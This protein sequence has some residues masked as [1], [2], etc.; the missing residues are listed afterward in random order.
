VTRDTPSD[1][2]LLDKLGVKPGSRVAV[3]E[4]ADDNFWS[5]LRRRT[6]EISDGGSAGA[7][8]MVVWQV[9]DIAELAGLAA[10]EAW[11]R[12]HGALWAVWR[13]GRPAL[14]E[15]HVRDAALAA[16]LVDV[17]VVRFSDTL[18]ALKLVIPKARR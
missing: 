6:D 12:P 2:P 15:N 17:K 7:V 10:M 1:K 8:D 3:L 5:E 9:D 13:K 18:S 4:V 14:T 11:I 16:G